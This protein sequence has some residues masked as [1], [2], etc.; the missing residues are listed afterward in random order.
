MNGCQRKI[1]IK[2]ILIILLINYITKKNEI[3][4]KEV[5]DSHPKISIYLPIYKKFGLKYLFIDYGLN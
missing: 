2:F 5:K 1:F 3:K 4:I